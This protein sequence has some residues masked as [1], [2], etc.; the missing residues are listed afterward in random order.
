MKKL[1]SLAVLAFLSVSTLLAQPK[2]M[3]YW[4]QRVEYAMEIDMDVNTHRFKGKQTINYFNNSPDTLTKVY[5]HLY[6]NAFQPGSMMDMR[7]LN[8]ADPDRRVGDLISKLKD[9]EIG[10]QH[11][12]SLKQNGKATTFK[13]EGTILEVRLNNPI[14]PGKEAKLE[15]EFEGQ[16]PVQIRRS[17]R[18]N[19]EGIAYSMSQWYPKL[20]E[21]DYLG[22]HTNPYIGRE[23]HGVW[24]DFDVKI[25]IDESYTVGGT[26]YLQNAKNIGH[27]YEG[28]AEKQSGKD[29]KLTWHFKAP[30]VHDF[31]WAADPDYKHTT[32]KVANGPTLHFLYQETEENKENWEKLPGMMVKAMEF[33]NKNYG[34]YPYEQYSFIQGGDGGMEYPMATLITGNRSFNSLLGVS[35]HE[36]LHSWY[37]G[38][39]A[40][41]ES[42][43]SWMDEGF[44]SYVSDITMQHLLDPDGTGNPHAG[45]YGG[46]FYQANSGDEEPL[47]T[48]ADHYQTNRSYG[49]NS[50]SKGAVFLHQLSYIIGQD[51]FMK[52]MR[53]YYN[54]WKFKHPTSIDFIR[55]MEKESGIQLDWYLEHFVYTTNQIDYGIKT[56][57]GTSDATYVTL[58]RVKEMM[59]PVDLHVEYTDGSKEIFYIPLRI[60]RG[61]KNVEDMNTQRMLLEE[62]PWTN[63]TY[64]LKINKKASDIKRIEI[65]A[66]QRMADIDRSN[67]VL[68][69]AENMTPYTDPTK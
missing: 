33:L 18:D 17:G 46:Y 36:L 55:V 56:A 48:H 62:W 32:A 4:Q 42:L 51:A 35:V 16:V 69:F 58:E 40:T 13:V 2:S 7:S 26:G 14:L 28:I 21:Y 60:M 64:T 59:M 57:L 65:D 23:F 63:P 3:E 19:A 25:S 45:S 6:F 50:Y 20:A 8:I 12:E 31:M 5:Y 52:G 54:T 49:I 9:D 43:Y 68:D 10:Y 34:K 66:T 61:A 22:W 47:T 30:N 67:N 44:T 37:Q 24:G 15:M 39:L 38:V 27:G 29:G 53:R 1:F 11:V 41:N